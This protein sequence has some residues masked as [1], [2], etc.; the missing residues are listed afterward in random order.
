MAEEYGDLF[1]GAEK[2]IQLYKHATPERYNFIHLDLQS[3][4]PKLFKNFDELIAEGERNMITPLP[5]EELKKDNVEE[6]LDGK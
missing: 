2:F 4:P 5:N 1:G 3:N 6:N